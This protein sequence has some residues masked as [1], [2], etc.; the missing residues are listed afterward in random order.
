MY[1]LKLTH[2][3]ACRMITRNFYISGHVTK[4]FVK[5][6]KKT[7]LSEIMFMVELYI[8]WK[9]IQL[10]HRKI[11]LWICFSKIVKDRLTWTN[12]INKWTNIYKTNEQLWTQTVMW[13]AFIAQG[14]SGKQAKRKMIM[15]IVILVYNMMKTCSRIFM[16]QIKSVRSFVSRVWLH[17]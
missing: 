1:K 12:Q 7:N 8:N 6:K 2:S 14:G 17:L 11:R 3:L 16:S 15:K 9:K 10:F 4:L 13:S 5:L